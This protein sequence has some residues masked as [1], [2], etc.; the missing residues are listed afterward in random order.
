MRRAYFAIALAMLVC[1]AC[2][3]SI[4]FARGRQTQHQ[5]PPSAAKHLYLFF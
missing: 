2:I 5:T 4:D 3:I 1:G